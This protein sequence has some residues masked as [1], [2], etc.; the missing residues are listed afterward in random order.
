MKIRKAKKF[1]LREVA[2][3][4]LEGFSEPPFNEK[5][6]L[7]EGIKKIKVFDKYCDI[8]VAI[9]DKQIVG[10][11]I[12]NPNH[13]KIGEIAFGEDIGVKKEFRKKGIAT[14]LMKFA[15]KYYKE[16]DFKEFMGII[17]K[18]AKSYGLIKKLNLKIEKQDILIKKKL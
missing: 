11:L 8:W 3:I 6:T 4:Y 2:K 12:I 9:I 10:F 5:W 17:N 18:G 1:E 15:F 7:Q 16:N 14:K 13:W